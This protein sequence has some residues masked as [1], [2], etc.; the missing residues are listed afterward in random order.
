MDHVPSEDLLHSVHPFPGTYQD[1]SG[2]S[3][4]PR[5]TL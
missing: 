5:T 2:K 4:W 1:E 3:A